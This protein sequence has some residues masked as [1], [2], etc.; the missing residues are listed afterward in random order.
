MCVRLMYF[1]WFAVTFIRLFYNIVIYLDANKLNGANVF[2]FLSFDVQHQEC[3]PANIKKSLKRGRYYVR[4]SA[5]A[6]TPLILRPDKK[7]IQK[8]WDKNP[9]NCSR[10]QHK[11]VFFYYNRNILGG[12]WAK[13][14]LTPISKCSQW[15]LKH[16]SL[17]CKFNLHQII[18]YD[19]VLITIY[20]DQSANPLKIHSNY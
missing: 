6:I 3:A 20:S 19:C 15:H 10:Q 8:S 13:K 5:L 12:C 2:F 4:F 9:L 14:K 1:K 7:L 11:K 16:F 18:A 17:I